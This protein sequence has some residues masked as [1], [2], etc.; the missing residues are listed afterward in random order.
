MFEELIKQTKENHFNDYTEIEIAGNKV[1]VYK[2]VPIEFKRSLVN[3]VLDAALTN[4]GIYDE[5]ALDIGFAL[6]I[7]NLYTNIEVTEDEANGLNAFD[8]YNYFDKNGYFKQIVDCINEDEYKQLF[9]YV[10]EQRAANEKGHIGIISYINN[11]VD[12]LPKEMNE[13]L[14]A[15]EKVQDE[16]ENNKKVVDITKIAEKFNKEG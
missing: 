16:N 15:F 12:S 6:G 13:L 9:D 2:Y 3:T 11:L 14:K 10:V 4:N 1:R 7:I 5:V 8:I